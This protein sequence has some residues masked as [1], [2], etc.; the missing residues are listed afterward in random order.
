MTF[1]EKLAQF[2]EEKKTKV[3]KSGLFLTLG[4]LMLI[5]GG[6]LIIFMMEKTLLMALGIALAVIGVILIIVGSTIRSKII[7]KFKNEFMIEII[8]EVYPDAKYDAN[9]GFSEKTLLEPGFFRSPDRYYVKD[10]I[11]SSYENVPFSQCDYDLQEEHT[12]TDSRGNTT[13][14][15][16]TY[17]KGRMI[18][19]DFKR[20]FN[21]VVRILETKW[22]G[23]STSGLTKVETESLEFNK[24]FKTYATDSLKAFYIL[25]P[26]VQLKLLELESKFKGSIF[27]SFQAGKL[28]VAINDSK[29]TLDFSIKKDL[30]QDVINNLISQISVPAAIINELHLNSDKYTRSDEM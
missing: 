13:T 12:S 23:A 14:T 26:Q 7:K 19:I 2:N 18:I 25:T 11:S 10:L 6:I 15:Y 4:T 30:N 22:L 29:G 3:K 16:Q 27:F 20:E 24:K 5:G 21:G 1:E 17:A 28:Y 8:H 9:G